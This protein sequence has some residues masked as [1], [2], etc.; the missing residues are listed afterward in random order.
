M[1]DQKKKVESL[2]AYL[3][4]VRH[5]LG[6]QL[7]VVHE[8]ISQVID[9]L[10]GKDCSKCNNIL[11]PS[12]E[13]ADIINKSIV[14]LLS[15]SSFEPV[16]KKQNGCIKENEALEKNKRELLVIINHMIRIPLTIIKEGLSLILDEIPGKLDP[17]QIN[18]LTEVNKSADKLIADIENI[19]NTPWGN[20]QN[21]IGE[22]IK[23]KIE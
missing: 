6:N 9:G 4:F 12:L 15:I 3:S 19:L 14:N 7:F 1:T 22:E 18:I 11:K 17:K 8:G 2:D 20:V 23:Y 16:L 21:L 10:G 13:Y 5:E